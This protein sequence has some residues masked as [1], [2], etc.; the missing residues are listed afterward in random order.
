MYW[1]GRIPIETLENLSPQ[2][3]DWIR[4]QAPNPVQDSSTPDL[5]WQT[6]LHDKALRFSNAVEAIQVFELGPRP[7]WEGFSGDE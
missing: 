5:L 3:G 1:G 7:S 6:P 2:A 4:S